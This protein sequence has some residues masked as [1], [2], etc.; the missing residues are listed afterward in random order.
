[1]E[2]R[3]ILEDGTVFHG[4][5]FGVEGES[6]G[7]VVFNT[8]M[9]GYQEVLTDP[10]YYG[11]IVT[12]TYPLIGNYGVNVEDIESAHPHVR[13]FVVREW[14]EH[15]SNWRST[16]SIDEYLK[17]HNIM[18]IHGIDTRMLTKKI[19]VKGTMAG[20]I[21]TTDK[22][23][24]HYVDQMNVE[25]LLPRDQI[26]RVTTRSTYRCPGEGYRVVAMD[27]GMKAGILR[28]LLGRKCDVTVVPAETSAE[29]ILGW[30][31]HGVFLSNGPGNPEDMTHA[32]ETI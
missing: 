27:F 21:T 9:T 23:V 1:M 14:S 7:Q 2:A 18:G 20:V 32:I 13:G 26:A 25:D 6:F 31:P 10:S 15:P 19:R 5:G 29:E 3:L 16:G 12:M 8:G 22:P 28:S 11:Q 4:E 30:K 24:E 17:R